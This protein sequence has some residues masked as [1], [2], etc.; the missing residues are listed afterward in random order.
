MSYGR[1]LLGRDLNREREKLLDEQDALSR[2]AGKKSL[3]GTVGGTLGG[4]AAT[5]LTG[6]A[7]A[8]WV[9]AMMAGTGTAAGNVL[10]QKASGV[11]KIDPKSI[12]GGKFLRSSRDDV[13]KDFKNVDR[14]LLES[15]L[16]GGLKSGLTAGAGQYLKLG[17][18]A[19]KAE[20][21]G[22]SAAEIAKI[23]KGVGLGESVKSS[24]GAQSLVKGKESIGKALDKT[25]DF[26]K[27]FAGD[28]STGF[29]NTSFDQTTLP[30]GMSFKEWQALIAERQG[31]YA[32]SEAAKTFDFSTLNKDN[33][34]PKGLA[35]LKQEIGSKA[36]TLKNT[37]K[38]NN[39]QSGNIFGNNMV[40]ESGDGLN[41]IGTGKVSSSA[42][43]DVPSLMD[44]Y[45]GTEGMN[46]TG[47]AD[48]GMALPSS[49]YNNVPTNF[50]SITQ[51]N[52]DINLVNKLSSGTMN[53][54]KRNDLHSLFFPS[55]N[56]SYNFPNIGE[57]GLNQLQKS[58]RWQERLFGDL[59]PI[60][61]GGK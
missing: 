24:W 26:A 3:W 47:I 6:G 60:N 2:K 56:S 48:E 31:S 38:A 27:D 11:G 7:A 16:V 8:P 32:A 52:P 5:A 44:M 10:G 23:K 39:L 33:L 12:S 30:D 46:F 19:K 29:K 61:F 43:S 55:N 57:E 28:L 14:D 1:A 20:E 54:N 17:V 49:T 45:E 13:V 42:V 36:N 41:M 25:K 37:M 59:P 4:L 22:S 35:L 15:A 9:A 40:S 34:D 58:L 53:R 21:L 18:D 50:G 51:N